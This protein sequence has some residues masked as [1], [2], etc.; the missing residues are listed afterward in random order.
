MDS[1]HF[2]H[3]VSTLGAAGTRRRLL[4]FSALPLAGGLAA[5]LID[6]NESAAKNKKKKHKKKKCPSKEEVCAD[7]CGRV[8]YKCRGKKK[9]ADCGEC[10]CDVCAS[11][12]SFT[13]VQAAIDAADPGDTIR[14]CL[15][16]YTEDIEIDKDLTILGEEGAI[17][18]TGLQ[19]TGVDS[20][21]R[22]SAGTVTL[23][24]LW[25][26]GGNARF[27]G[28]VANESTLTLHRCGVFGNTTDLDGGG[29]FNGTGATLKMTDSYVLSNT[30]ITNG[31]GIT[32][33]GT[34]TLS[35]CLVRGNTAN[36]RGGG[37][38][39]DG[40]LK[41]TDC[42]VRGNEAAHEGGAIGNEGKLTMQACTVTENN[43][44]IGAGGIFNE[45]RATLTLIDC[46]VSENMAA[47]FGGGIYNAF[48]ITMTDCAVHNNTTSNVGGG[49]FNDSGAGLEMIDCAVFDN[50]ASDDGGGIYNMGVVNLHAGTTVTENTAGDGGG[51]IWNNGFS[52][53]GTTTC[54]G[55]SSVSGNT[56]NDC[57][58]FLGG[59]CD[60]C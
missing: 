11:G 1:E 25:I 9:T 7:K 42:T 50:T 27:G 38:F 5:F 39:N 41:M 2:D 47:D 57:F 8:T 18:A 20:V 33:A 29:I 32:N 21:I 53:S 3:L 35:G 56:P 55:G 52:G 40:T 45:D 34:L 6:D 46:T 26:T 51:G 16:T 44:G 24:S 22:V 31:G 19:G 60:G 37:I 13:S 28:G 59:V 10:R 48:S 43:A 54:S 14:L 17:A 49:F 12:C 58:E 15:E 36:N 4:R 23:E 30:A